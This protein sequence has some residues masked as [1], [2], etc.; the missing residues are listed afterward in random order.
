MDISGSRIVDWNLE[1]DNHLYIVAIGDTADPLYNVQSTIGL[2]EL[3]QKLREDLQLTHR[4]LIETV[5]AIFCWACR[6]FAR[7]QTCQ[8]NGNLYFENVVFLPT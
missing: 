1:T 3:A 8:G 7:L 6:H 5:E 2:T 4:D